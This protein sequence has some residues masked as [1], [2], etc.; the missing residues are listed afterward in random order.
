LRPPANTCNNVIAG[1]DNTTVIG[2][3]YLPSANITVTGNSAIL[4]PVYGGV[5]AY[6]VTVNGTASLAVDRGN[7]ANINSPAARLTR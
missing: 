4:A 7:V 6:T 5:F 1:H 2:A 3:L